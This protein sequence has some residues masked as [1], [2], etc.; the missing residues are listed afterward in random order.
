MKSD[1]TIKKD[2]LEELRWQ[3]EVEDTQIG[4]TV[5]EGVVTL[6]GVLKTFP[7]KLAAQR[8]VKRVSGVR[9]L[10]MDIQI[11][12]ANSGVYTDSDIALAVVN[13]L[14]WNAV[15]PE[16]RIF[17]KVSDG[18]V[19]LSGKL[20]WSYQKYAVLNSVQNLAGIREIHAQD[21]VVEPRVR[22]V[23]VKQK[24]EA[25]L[26]RMANLNATAVDVEVHGDIVYLT[27]AVR[28]V[29]EKEAAEHA[30]LR[31]PGIRKVVNQL[32]VRF[33]PELQI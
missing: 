26:E 1:A 2:V 32:K 29:I 30:A 21:L 15:V 8:A 5:K 33:H 27:G 19:F 23:A 6:T 16:D 3:S 25:A 24:I 14:S 9:G 7:Q 18:Q 10:A 31:A 11:Q 12:P 22:V 13:A 28:S 20:E 4:V 17:V